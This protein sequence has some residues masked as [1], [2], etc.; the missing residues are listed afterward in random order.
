MSAV[1]FKFCNSIFNFCF[2]SSVERLKSLSNGKRFSD[3]FYEIE[4]DFSTADLIVSH[5][6]SFDFSFMRAEYERLNKT[7]IYK[8]SFCS[9]KKTTTLCKLKRS[10]G[11]AYKYPKLSELC[12]FLG[13]TDNEVLTACKGLFGANVGYHDARFDTTAVCLAVNKGVG[14]YTEFDVLKDF[15]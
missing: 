8:D 9:M 3:C 12:S 15:L 7:F 4:K 13:I 2:A 5:N 10:C 14:T 6:T 11:V 1:Y